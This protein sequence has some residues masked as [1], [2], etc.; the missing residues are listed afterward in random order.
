MWDK[1]KQLTTYDDAGYEIL[2][3]G[4]GK[5]SAAVSQAISQWQASTYHNAVILNQAPWN[6][7]PWLAMGCSIG[8]A[9]SPKV[10]SSGGYWFASCW[11]GFETDQT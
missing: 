2:V 8:L 5:F 3:M 7:L 6:G 9:P 1:P 11:F 10:T 4:Y